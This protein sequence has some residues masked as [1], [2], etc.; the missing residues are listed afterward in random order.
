MHRPLKFRV[1]SLHNKEWLFPNPK[2]G[3]HLAGSGNMVNLWCD[4]DKGLSVNA[5]SDG[6]VEIQQFTG[7]K[8][9][10]G[11]EI[12]EGDV[13]KDY[14]G[15]LHKIFYLDTAASFEL[16]WIKEYDFPDDYEEPILNLRHSFRLEVIGNIFENP[17]LL[18]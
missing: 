15:F 18:K 4:K 16:A 14:L 17:E 8:D 10:N 9:K 2:I 11:R 3:G 13:V 6:C 5:V 1:W 12:Y 7:L